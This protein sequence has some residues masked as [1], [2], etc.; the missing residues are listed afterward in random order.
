MDTATS[1]PHPVDLHALVRQ[2][3]ALDAAHQAKIGA[4]LSYHGAT[5]CDTNGQVL[6]NLSAAP[7][8]AAAAVADYVAC[9][10]RQEKMLREREEQTDAL[11]AQIQT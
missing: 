1:A 6:V 3:G 10:D 5:L 11:R 7:P 9:A 2:I 4:I 8:A